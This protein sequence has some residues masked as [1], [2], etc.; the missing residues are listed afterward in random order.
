LLVNED[1][2]KYRK[3]DIP[4]EIPSDYFE[5]VKKELTER[6]SKVKNEIDV[7]IKKGN[8]VLVTEK[9]AELERIEKTNINLRKGKLTKQQ[10]IDARL[11]PNLTTAKHIANIS[12]E[13]GLE[14]A[15]NSIVI[16]GGISF[17]RN[18]IAVFKGD[19]EPEEAVDDI[20]KDAASAAALGYG[21][22]FV[23]AA[24]K[25][26][27][28]N[29]TSKFVR[30]LSKTNFPG[31]VITT[32]FE[33]GKTLSRFAGGELDGTGCLTELGEKGTGMLASGL[34][35]TVGQVIIP[36]PVVGGFIGGMIGYAMSST[37]YNNLVTVLN[38]ANLAH[39]ERLRIQKECQAAIELIKEYRMEM[40]NVINNYLQEHNKVFN[41]AIIDMEIAYNTSDADGFI[42]GANKIIKQLN[43]EPLFENMREF[44]QKVESST[45]F[46]I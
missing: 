5:G 39:D 33:T 45:V 36:I 27:M 18:T 2:D 29:H 8:T 41:E 6:A 34:G 1:W 32:V 21:T 4:L 35:A 17:I 42:N 16:G 13:A 44:N 7:A 37:Y 30:S 31:I 20:A 12:N 40:E 3:A 43:G 38:E 22:G 14:A 9:K 23:G 19:K 11:H 10:A 15:K 46:S 25:G 24:L 28:Q 26:N